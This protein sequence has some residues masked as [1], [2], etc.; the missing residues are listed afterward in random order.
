MVNYRRNPTVQ[1]I[2]LVVLSAVLLIGLTYFNLQ[3]SRTNPGGNDFLVH[4]VGTRAFFTEGISPYSDE[5][6]IRIQT[7]AYGRPAEAGEHELRVAYPLYSML[8]F[9]PFALISD[10]TTARALWMTLLECTLV[11]IMFLSIRLA[12]WKPRPL[13][14]AAMFVFGLLW[15]HSLRPLINGNAVILIALFIIG[16]LTALKNGQDELAGLL[17]ALSTIKPQVVVVFYLFILLWGIRKRRFKVVGWMV[18]VVV[19][20]VLTAALFQS[21]WILQN[22]REVLRYPGYNPPGTLQAALAYYLPAMGARVGWIIAG[23]LG[24]VMLL[25][26]WLVVRWDFRGFLWTACFT[27]VVSQWIGI[28]TD[29]G[30]FIVLTPAI[31][32]SFAL[33]EE[34]WRRGGRIMTIVSLVVLFFGIWAI[35]LATVQYGDQPQQAPIMFLPLPL[36]MLITLFWVRWWAVNPPR[37]WYEITYDK[38]NPTRYSG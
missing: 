35:F 28:Q 12:D 20:M 11:I 4:W 21:D 9:L 17:F 24:A 31:L 10:F 16:G 23:I 38:E 27:L 29:P 7:L 1:F 36:M 19:L 37:S 30:N 8:M 14:L 18:G 22:L 2:I 13:L 33:W 25:E 6:A 15:Y 34:R 5:A 32:L 3:Y 26:W